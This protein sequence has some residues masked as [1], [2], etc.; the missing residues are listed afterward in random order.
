MIEDEK[1]KRNQNELTALV[2]FAGAGGD[3]LGL[4]RA[5]F[6]IIGFVEKNRKAV[7]TYR[8][9]F[10]DVPIVGYDITEIPD[11]V[12]E[13]FKGKVDLISAGFPC[14]G[15]SHAGKKDPNDPR[16]K[17]F[18]EFVRATDII[19]PR[20]ILGE[21]V[22]GLLHR[23]TDDGKARVADVIVD[24][25]ES[26]GYTMAE[27]KVLN[28]VDYGVPQKRRRVFF[29]GNREGIKFE[30]P[31]PITGGTKK[32]TIRNIL[33]PSLEGAVKFEPEKLGLKI[34]SFLEVDSKTPVIGKPH[35][36]LVEKLEKGLLSYG[37]R[38]SPYHAEIVNID[39]PVKTIHSGYSFQPRLFVP[40]K[41]GNE[42]FLRTFTIS[43]LAQIQGFPKDYKFFGR[44]EEIIHQIGDAVPPPL[45]EVLAKK[46]VQYMKGYFSSISKF[47]RMAHLNFFPL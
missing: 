4:T 27:P 3:S 17:L 10:P 41:R 35:P 47:T 5:G 2:L 8:M 34:E 7:N 30:F 45:I 14:E 40:V 6:K 36:Y 26:I 11:S 37:K 31:K 28:A 15:F 25:F 18:W 9:N 1:R 44:K 42:F 12:F 13:K 19:K 46:I 22:F 39:A 29:I 43:E 32:P 21:N 38:I 23:M 16:N 24:A 33:E 20:W